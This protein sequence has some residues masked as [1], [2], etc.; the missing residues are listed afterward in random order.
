[1]HRSRP[2]GRVQHRGRLRVRLLYR[3]L[4]QEPGGAPGRHHRD[5]LWTRHRSGEPL[6]PGVGRSRAAHRAVGSGD[7]THPDGGRRAPLLPVQQPGPPDRA[8]VRRRRRRVL[9]VHRP[10]SV[11]E[12]RSR[13]RDP[14]HLRA[15]HT[16]QP[17]RHQSRAGRR[18]HPGDLRR[19]H[20]HQR[21]RGLPGP[22]G[23][24]G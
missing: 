16:A 24:G 11:R 19:R 2:P 22:L 18:P 21:P 1:M 14:L 20:R 23:A 8:P 6:R 7:P 4:R 10:G 9:G 5:D 17:H 15:G 3:Q 12:R 13:V